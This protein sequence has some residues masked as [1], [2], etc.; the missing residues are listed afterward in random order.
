MITY[1]FLKS[2]AT[3]GVT[4]PSSGVEKELH[5][6]VKES[7]R[8]MEEKGYTVI[9]GNTVWTQDKAKS[10]P[11]KKRA[12]EFNQMVQNSHIDL[13]IPPWGGELLIEML[14][15]VDFENMKEKWILGYSDTSMLLFAITLKTGIATAHGTNLIDLRGEYSDETTAMW[16]AVLSTKSGDY[17]IQ[18]SSEKY[19]EKWQHDNPS[20][21]VY[22]LTKPTYWK[23]VRDKSVNMQG[24]LLG[25]CIDII[26]HLIGTPYGDVEKFRKEKINGEP[27][28]WY[29]ENCEM[30]TTDLRRSLVQMKLAGWFENCSGI[31]FG[32][33]DANQPIDNY[34][35][36]D[37]YKD[38]FDEL[39]IPIIYDIDCGHVPPQIT[40]IN[41]AYAE[42]EV[43]DGKGTVLQRFI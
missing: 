1:P 40:F 29:F 12:E 13:I 8:R 6:L 18:H 37:V 7:S 21:C 30:S 9:S 27:I 24:R 23:S 32:R 39:N 22:H 20:P 41:G 33:S 25:G 43:K 19:Q 14:S 36:V 15:S 38:L 2:E 11:A 26:R 3:I 28:L 42:V 10:A 16:K 35:V 31:L 4:A 5:D 17:I 34:T